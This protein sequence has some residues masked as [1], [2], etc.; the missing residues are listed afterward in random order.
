MNPM[1]EPWRGPHGGVPPFDTTQVSQF[2]AA[3][4]EGMALHL[5]EIDAIGNDPNPPTFD[6]TYVALERSGQPLSRAMTLF[7][8]WSSSRSTPDFRALE[9]KLSPRLAQFRDRITQHPKL[10]AKL[11][12]VHDSKP[13][14]NPEQQRLMEV[15]YTQFVRQGAALDASQK[16][17]LSKLNQQLAT[18]FTRFAQNQLADEEQKFLTIDSREGLGGLSD[19]QISAAAADAKE[20]GLEGKWVI[21][22]TRS[23]MEP[24]LTS[25]TNRAL[26]EAG[27][28][29]WVK[30]GDNGDANDN[31]AIASDILVL[32][33]KRAK[34]LGA[35]TFAHWQLGDMMAKTPETALQLMQAVWKPAVEQ[36]KRDVVE[37]QRIVDAEGGGFQIQPWDY[38]HYAEKL[39]KQKYDLDLDEVKP[40]LQLE[41]LREAM[42]ASAQAL[43]DLSF[44]RVEGLPTFHADVQ[45]YEVKR[46][47]THVGYWYFDPYQRAG[48]QSGA[49]MSAYRDQHRLEGEVTTL[50]SNNSNFVKPGPGEPVTLS[51]DDARTMFHEFGHA[52]H[53][54]NSSVTYPSLS[55][56]NTTRDFVE[57]PSQFNE[58]F[59]STPRVLRMLTNSKGESIP[60][61]LLERIEKAR[62]FNQGFATAE[63]QASALLDMKL[64]LAGEARVDVREFEKRVCD[65]IGV[66]PQLVP[67]HRIPAF[68]H[69]FSGDGYAAAYYSYIW[70][71]VLEADAFAAFKEAGDAFHKPTAER[72]RVTVM[73]VG[74]TVDPAIAFRNFRGRDPRADALLESKGFV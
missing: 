13:T 30:R 49:W 1:L 38:R 31:N 26:R 45:V 40:Y 47:S 66:P 5:E 62:T 70:A 7:Y 36:F 72:L 24:F 23:S 59:L 46:G 19:A 55:G 16:A 44:V 6:N 4:E 41:K 74:N 43:Y 54:L 3:I 20:R 73:S 48:K 56:T 9:E 33:A 14:L 10:F 22:N 53:G 69:I 11:K 65:E 68:G 61:S 71:E 57:L 15:T 64:H 50:V 58:N 51:W 42:F 29:L 18:L 25:S 2:E 17:E 67:R 34:L 52:L 35:E 27:W 8:V 12:F 32:R 21:S 39:R 60:A 37:C 28:N 63:A